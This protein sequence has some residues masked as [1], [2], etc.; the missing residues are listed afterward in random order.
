VFNYKDS[1]TIHNISIGI[2][3]Y[4]P[5]L[6]LL[7]RLHLI[8]E[9][10]YPLYIFD[11]SPEDGTVREFCR[12][13]CNYITSGKNLGLGFGLST[14]S[15]QAYYDEYPTLVF[16]DQ[17]TVFNIMTLEFIESFYRININNLKD[18]SCITFNSNCCSII[19]KKNEYIFKD[20]SIT[21]NSGSM[22]LLQNL[23]LL[24]WFDQTYFVDCVDYE[25]S[26]NSNNKKLKIGLCSV[27]P[28]FDHEKE[29]GD[30]KLYAFGKLRKLR[31]Y[32]SSRVFGT[33]QS[34]M[35]LILKA[36]S[37]GN[38]KFIWIMLKSI[39]GYIF[40]QAYVRLINIDNIKFGVKND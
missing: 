38:K 33:I 39:S 23:K 22:F 20:I 31:K 25:F 37:T 16:F 12:E 8:I 30:I 7:K 10:K 29:Q 17:D 15:A 32:S 26:L 3:I 1:T 6:S 40:W 19:D 14:L 18:Y 28:G 4:K 24:N 13:K 2:V 9:N 36:I 27:T 35:R 21:I 5:E 34:S 11:N